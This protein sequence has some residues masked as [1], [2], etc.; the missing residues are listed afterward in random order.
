[1]GSLGIDQRDI[2]K[3]SVAR[4]V[5]VVEYWRGNHQMPNERPLAD[6]ATVMNLV[7]TLGQARRTVR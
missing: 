5:C 6:L 2:D 4:T 1:M 3:Q 7:S